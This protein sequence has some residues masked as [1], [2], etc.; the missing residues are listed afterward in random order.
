MKNT[1]FLH[2]YALLGK[3]QKMLVKVATRSTKFGDN[4][5]ENLAK[6]FEIRGFQAHDALGHVS[7]L[8]RVLVKLNISQE[9]LI[10]S[11][12]NWNDA[13]EKVL[14]ADKYT[15]K[16]SDQD[17]I[18]RLLGVDEN[19]RIRVTK[20]K[21][22][23]T[24]LCKPSF[25]ISE[26]DSPDRNTS[27]LFETFFPDTARSPDLSPLDFFLWGYLKGTVYHTKPRDLEE[28][29]ERIINACVDLPPRMR[30]LA[31]SGKNVSNK[32]DVF[33]SEES[34]SEIKNGAFHL[35]F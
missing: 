22:V 27:I 18:A 26:S 25:L 20:T 14:L 1:N 21:S 10:K 24:K 11:S 2:L 29:R 5:L 12:L 31:V 17:G 9:Q 34:D 3:S 32:I 6:R 19:G 15:Y 16:E 13:K 30:H 33:L 35:K 23:T 7:V 4:K 28:L 8:K